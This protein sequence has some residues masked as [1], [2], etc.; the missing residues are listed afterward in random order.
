LTARRMFVQVEHADRLRRAW[1]DK[2]CDHPGF[3]EEYY[4]GS[5]TGDYVCERCGASL[6]ANEMREIERDR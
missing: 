2:P 5:R 6:T 1:G 3:D 4:L